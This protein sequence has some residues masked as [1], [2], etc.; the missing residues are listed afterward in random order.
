MVISNTRQATAEC[1]SPGKP[2]T[3]TKPSPSHL[4]SAKATGP[5]AKRG[6]RGGGRPENKGGDGGGQNRKQ[7]LKATLRPAARG[8][9]PHHRRL[10]STTTCHHLGCNPTT[11]QTPNTSGKP[12]PCLSPQP[13]CHS[14]IHRAPSSSHSPDGH[15]RKGARMEKRQEAKQ[16]LHPW[17]HRLQATHSKGEGGEH[18]HKANNT[19]HLPPSL[20]PTGGNLSFTPACY[21]TTSFTDITRSQ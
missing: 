19:I 4:F 18:R 8:H 12:S 15:S 3:S 7:P 20:N 11:D 5:A 21:T 6:A 16:A 13:Y 17:H 14:P 2:F 10:S 1:I 9:T